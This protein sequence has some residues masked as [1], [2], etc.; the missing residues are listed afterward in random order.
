MRDVAMPLHDR[1]RIA[2][3]R[4]GKYV[5]IGKHGAEGAADNRSARSGR[6]QRAGHDSIGNYGRDITAGEERLSGKRAH[7]SVC[8]GIHVAGY[9]AVSRTEFRC[10][11]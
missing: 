7:N 5:D 11:P 8:E 4:P 1:E 3:Q 10:A 6:A 2:C 9:F